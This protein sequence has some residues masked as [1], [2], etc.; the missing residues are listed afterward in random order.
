MNIKRINKRTKKIALHCFLDFN[1]ITLVFLAT[2]GSRGEEIV[3]ATLETQDGIQYV[4][5]YNAGSKGVDFPFAARGES[6]SE[7]IDNL[8]TM[9]TGRIIAKSG[10]SNV[11]DVPNWSWV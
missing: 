8:V 11:I 2:Y 6:E 1:N 4:F 3:F 7:A 5:P 10:S 9:I